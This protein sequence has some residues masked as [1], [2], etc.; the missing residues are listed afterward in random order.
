MLEIFGKEFRL[1]V[2]AYSTIFFL[3]LVSTVLRVIYFFKYR[4]NLIDLN[5]LVVSVLLI[6]SSYSLFHNK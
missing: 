4:E 3:S 2:V 1:D 6:Y 5:M